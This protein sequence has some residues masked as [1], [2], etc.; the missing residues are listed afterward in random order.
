MLKHFS[1][2]ISWPTG[3]TGINE[4]PVLSLYPA[5]APATGK[6]QSQTLLQCRSSHWSRCFKQQERKQWGA[7]PSAFSAGAATCFC[8]PPGKTGFHH[9]QAGWGP[10]GSPCTHTAK[11]VVPHGPCLLRLHRSLCPEAQP[12]LRGERAAK[13]P[14]ASIKCHGSTSD[15]YLALLGLGEMNFGGVIAQHIEASQGTVLVSA[16]ELRQW[17]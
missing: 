1:W 6:A 2:D 8:Y 14:A 4:S 5:K 16:Q 9:S 15:L 13:G 11:L 3:S 7:A 12:R 17:V 10:N